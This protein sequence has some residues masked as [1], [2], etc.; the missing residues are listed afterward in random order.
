MFS[1]ALKADELALTLV[2]VLGS[3]ISVYDYL[4]VIVAFYMREVPEPGPT[5]SPHLSVGLAI[6]A[7][8]VLILGVL[9]GGWVSVARAAAQ[10]LTND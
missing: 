5:P 9:P 10:S 4:R 7:A 6:F 3:V 2:G 8:V 1:A